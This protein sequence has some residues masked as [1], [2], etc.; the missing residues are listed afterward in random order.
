MDEERGL[1]NVYFKEE[2]IEKISRKFMTKKY[3]EISLKP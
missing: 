1:Y 2:Q 3:N